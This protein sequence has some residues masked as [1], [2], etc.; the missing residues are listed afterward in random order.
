MCKNIYCT[1]RVLLLSAYLYLNYNTKVLPTYILTQNFQYI[2]FIYYIYILL[3]DI[4]IH[5]SETF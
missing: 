2:Y 4:N 1:N 3:I 5:I